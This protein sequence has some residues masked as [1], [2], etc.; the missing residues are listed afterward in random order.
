MST[1]R[2]VEGE[3]WVR[4]TIGM[5]GYYG[6]PP[7][8]PDGWRPTGDLVEIVGDR[9]EFRGRAS[10]IINVGGVKVHPLPIEE[11]IGAVDPASTSRGSAAAPTR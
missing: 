6:E 8:D 10:E 7:I 11:R 1:C 5:L 4:S 9:I 2:V 3:L